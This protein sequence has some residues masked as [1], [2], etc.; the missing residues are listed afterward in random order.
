MWGCGGCKYANVDDHPPP[1]PRPKYRKYRNR[2]NGLGGGTH[3]IY[4]T[5]SDTVVLL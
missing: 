3:S 1:P 5:Y 2:E 4:D